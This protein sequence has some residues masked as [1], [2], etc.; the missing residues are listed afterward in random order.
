LQDQQLTMPVKYENDIAKTA[1]KRGLITNYSTELTFVLENKWWII[2]NWGIIISLLP[3]E[4]TPK[5]FKKIRYG[6]FGDRPFF[7]SS[8]WKDIEVEFINENKVNFKQSGNSENF[9]S[10]FPIYKLTE[11]KETKQEE[12]IDFK[13][14]Y[15][16]E[17]FKILVKKYKEN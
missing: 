4:E 15:F 12:Y 6:R 16:F 8:P 13:E 17:F 5:G 3:E 11:P 14:N 2:S 9:N 1:K 7:Y 10:Y